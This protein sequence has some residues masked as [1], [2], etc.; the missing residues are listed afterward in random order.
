MAKD[1][2]EGFSSAL[3][4]AKDLGEKATKAAITQ[5]LRYAKAS[6]EESKNTIIGAGV[7]AGI[8]FAIGGS[9]GV[10]G[11]FG[12]IG[13]PWV[14]LLLLSGGFLGNR[15]GISKDKAE[16]DRK[17][18]DQGARLENLEVFLSSFLAKTRPKRWFATGQNAII[19][20]QNMVLWVRLDSAS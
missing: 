20:S 13:I 18:R 5:S 3:S 19:Q 10:V 2:R 1:F 8:G 17:R 16:L 6:P 15:L 14:V 9:I 7:G 4:S 12:G 11:F